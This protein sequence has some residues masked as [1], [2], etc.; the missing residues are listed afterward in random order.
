MRPHGR[1]RADRHHPRAWAVCD[2]CGFLFN[3]SDLQWQY[4]WA[5]NKLVNQNFLVCDTCYDEPQEQLRSIVLPADP[6]P[7]VN[8]RPEFDISNNN[9]ISPLGIAIGTMTQAAGLNAAFDANTNKPLFMSACKYVSING[10][11]SVGRN[12]SG[13]TDNNAG[14]TALRFQVWAPNNARLF[15]GGAATYTFDGSQDNTVWTQ[16]ATGTTVGGIGETLDVSITPTISYLYHRFALTGNGI[17]SV[18]LAQLKIYR[19]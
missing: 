8:P 9:P 5:G 10:V 19:A 2:G 18:S 3:K 12:W 16:L 15:G 14:V 11:N 6:T 13:L 1:A 7:I 4:E 17:S